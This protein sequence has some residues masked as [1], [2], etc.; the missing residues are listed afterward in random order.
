MSG[1]IK[2]IFI[3]QFIRK[4]LGIKTDDPEFQKAILAVSGKG[5]SY[6]KQVDLINQCAAKISDKESGMRLKTEC[7]QQELKEIYE[8]YELLDALAVYSIL[9]ITKAEKENELLR[10]ENDRLKG[11]HLKVVQ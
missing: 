10:Q 5:V 3:E 1:N 4:H 2:T 7:Y 8:A 9:R 6:E 11:K